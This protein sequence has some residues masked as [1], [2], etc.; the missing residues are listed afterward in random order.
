MKG[1][2]HPPLCRSPACTVRPK[3]AVFPASSNNVTSGFWES[4]MS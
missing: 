4:F 3:I 1:Q 2:K